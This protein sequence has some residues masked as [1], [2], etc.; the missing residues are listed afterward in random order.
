[1]SLLDTLSQS[2]S[3]EAVNEIS[4][5]IGADSDKTADALGVALPTLI[6]ALKRNAATPQG[7]ENLM[8]AL[9]RDHDGSILDRVSDFLGQKKYE[10]P[11]GGS[12]ILNHVFGSNRDRV[13]QGVSQASG[14]S[15]NA[16]S[17]LMKMLA[18]MV[19]AAIS[20]QVL[21]RNMSSDGL[22]DYLNQQEGELEKK[23]KKFSLLG[24]FLD[25][26]GD[27]DFDFQ[28][29]TKLGIGMLFKRR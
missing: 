25:Q 13:E 2:L 18:P 15:S 20:K 16:S 12:D 10:Q 1:M 21:S 23:E 19:L 17:Q 26:D 11:R 6:A 5:Q 14:L 27:G 7:A 9:S 24:R 4:S 28:D 22:A 29:L 3:G 8:G